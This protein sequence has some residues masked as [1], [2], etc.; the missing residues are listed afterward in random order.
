MN[1]AAA[2]RANCRR[3]RIAKIM[4]LSMAIVLVLSLVGSVLAGSR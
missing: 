4:A 2:S 3:R 1:D